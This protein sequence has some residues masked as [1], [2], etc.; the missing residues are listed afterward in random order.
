MVRYSTE[1]KNTQNNNKEKV[2]LIVLGEFFIPGK[3]FQII[4]PIIHAV[5]HYLHHM[6]N[7]TM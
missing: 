3:Q 1:Y 4:E 5:R 7:T 2:I 6:K